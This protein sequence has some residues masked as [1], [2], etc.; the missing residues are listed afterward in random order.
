MDLVVDSH[1]G[2]GYLLKDRVRDATRIRM[3][4]M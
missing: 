1:G 4:V 2:I 3:R